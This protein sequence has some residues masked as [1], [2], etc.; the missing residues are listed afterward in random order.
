[1][2][3]TAT[4][5]QRFAQVVLDAFKAAGHYTDEQVKAAGGPSSTWM[6]GA[7]KARDG[8]G[9]LRTVR[10]DTLD[11]I[12]AAAGWPQGTAR[13]VY[14]GAE[15]PSGVAQRA[16]RDNTVFVSYGSGKS[17]AFL[18][19]LSEVSDTDLLAELL[20]RAELREAQASA[21]GGEQRFWAARNEIVHGV[22]MSEPDARL[23]PAA[24]E[25]ETGLDEESGGSDHDEG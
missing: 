21:T 25:T 3:E 15:P 2:T 5:S 4:R 20:R 19:A 17:E 9:E 6:T 23:A 7:R 1:M 18:A 14:E 22:G 24:L 16:A 11:A 13:K 8:D 12:D 10:S